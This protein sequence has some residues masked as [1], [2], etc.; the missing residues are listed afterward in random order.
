MQKMIIKRTIDRH[1][2]LDLL[3]LLV[4]ASTT[5]A[6][7]PFNLWIFALIAPAILFLF[8]SAVSWKRAFLQGLFF[9]IGFFAT[10]VSWVYI[11]C[12]M[13]GLSV[14]LAG[15]ATGFFVL[16]MA[17]FIACN[18]LLANGLFKAKNSSRLLLVYPVSWVVFEWL[19]SVVLTGFPWV[20]LGYSQLNTPLSGFAPLASVYAVSF[21]CVLISASAVGLLLYSKR[22]KV[23]T[24]G[25]IVLIAGAGFAL[26]QIA[27]THKIGKNIRVT[28]IQGKIAPTLKWR[29]NWLV[30]TLTIY[31]TLTIA[32][33]KDSDLIIWPENAM[34]DFEQQL[35]PYLN[36]LTPE[37][38]KYHLGLISG[39]L[40]A[41][42]NESIYYNGARGFGLAKGMY[43]KH[44]LVPFGE[45]I[46]FEGVL[47]KL[48]DFLDIPM[49]HF[50]K[51]PLKQPHMSFNALKMA[52]FICYESA[53]PEQV[54]A[55]LQ[56]AD[57][58]VTLTDDG[59]F[60]ASIGPE[61][62][63]QMNQMRA[64]ET[65]RFM[66]NATN[67][68]ITNIVLPNGQVLVSVPRFVRVALQ[69]KVYAMTGETPWIRFGLMPLWIL[70]ALLII[71]A[72]LRR[73]KN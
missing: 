5:L 40:I 16:I 13:G 59:W 73:N 52:L 34:P 72:I 61:Q 60:G 15:L 71:V 26:K 53:Y 20:F 17:L 12:R 28:V 57:F 48:L 50:S 11:P 9:G 49:S 55:A 64:L 8:W 36:I 70:F 39:M 4:G 19:R 23:L 42:K 30:D 3:L 22:M 66:I 2:L 58:I 65:G 67:D 54:R 43:R 47:G 29:P 38:K 37:L 33:F 21:A 69:G 7:S 63:A 10:S 31:N 27:W 25:L 24:F 51:G 1:R 68:G 35:K 6:F 41:G 44:H 18:G 56:S 14:L 45:Y 32:H 46:L 62:H